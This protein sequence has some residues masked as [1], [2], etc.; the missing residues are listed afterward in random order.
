MNL[1]QTV[2]F[3]VFR[4]CTEKVFRARVDDLFNIIKDY[5]H[6]PHSLAFWSDNREETETHCI[7][8]K[9]FLGTLSSG[10]YLANSEIESAVYKWCEYLAHWCQ[11]DADRYCGTDYA[12]KVLNIHLSDC[13]GD[14]GL[15]VVCW[16]K[17]GKKDHEFHLLPID[18]N[19]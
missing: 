8:I 13:W 4:D 12:S 11:D 7:M 19:N 6:S 9:G 2:E 1:K 17:D 10:R 3:R 18:T 15:N 14:G 16:D 5:C